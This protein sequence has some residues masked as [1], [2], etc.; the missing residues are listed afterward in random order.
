MKRNVKGK[1]DLETRNRKVKRKVE[2]KVERTVK[3][4]LKR[5]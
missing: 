2:R 3:R 4:K 5:M 1:V